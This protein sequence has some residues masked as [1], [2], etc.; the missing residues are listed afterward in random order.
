MKIDI[1][2]HTAGNIDWAWEKCYNCGQHGGAVK[3]KRTEAY[4]GYEGYECAFCEPEIW[5]RR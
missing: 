5:G 4:H 2:L 3:V 1:V